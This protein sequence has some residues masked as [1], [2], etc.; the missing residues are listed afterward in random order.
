MEAR[1]YKHIRSQVRETIV[2]L[3]KDADLPSIG[4]RI[5]PGRVHPFGEAHFP[6]LTV[7]C[8][9][10]TVAT[11]AQRA[12]F[13][14]DVRRERTITVVIEGYAQSNEN[15][16]DALDD[17][18]IDVEMALI[19]HRKLEGLAIN[20]EPSSTDIGLVNEAGRKTGVVQMLF[21][22]V[23]HT[24]DGKLYQKAQETPVPLPGL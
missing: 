4:D 16:D 18:A 6:A 21:T 9:R 3:L 24:E 13:Y 14:G 22:A 19:P 1:F 12:G 23:V 17:I 8:R 15:L 10:E 2:R 7:Y 11:S 5:H 20:F